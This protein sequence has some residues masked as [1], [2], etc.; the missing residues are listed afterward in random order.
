MVSD[1]TF[2]IYHILWLVHFDYRANIEGITIIAKVTAYQFP[3][4]C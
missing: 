2:V 4:R 1:G 3:F